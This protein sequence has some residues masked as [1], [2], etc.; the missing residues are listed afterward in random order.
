MTELVAKIET[1]LHMDAHA[2]SVIG[3]EAN[4]YI[5]GLEYIELLF[6]YICNKQTIEI[7][8][9]PFGSK[10][11]LYRVHP[12]YI[13]QHNSR[14]FLLAMNHETQKIMILALDRIQKIDLSNIAYM[15]TEIDFA[16]YF[17]DVIGVTI[18]QDTIPEHILL[19]FSANRLPYVLS[20]P[21]HHS[22]KVKDKGQGIIEIIVIP[23]R[24]LEAQL[25]WFGDDIEVL[26]PETLRQQIAEKIAKMH[27]LYS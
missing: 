25:L 16:E 18:P 8:Y 22:Q 21:L 14:W 2:E 1:K 17:D 7:T 11:F 10:S 13:K 4:E 23:N 15:P 20:K 24:E 26:Q 27:D 19:R 12:Y 6:G 3:F 5:Q 9:K